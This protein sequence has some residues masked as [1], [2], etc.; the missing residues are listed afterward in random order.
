MR[1]ARLDDVIQYKSFMLSIKKLIS[2]L[3]NMCWCYEHELK[4]KKISDMKTDWALNFQG[5]SL[6]PKSLALLSMYAS[7]TILMDSRKN[8]ISNE[9]TTMELAISICSDPIN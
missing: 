2:Y 8:L 1:G 3:V 9:N 5:L 6:A 4:V 7:M